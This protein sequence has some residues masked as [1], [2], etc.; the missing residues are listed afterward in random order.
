MFFFYRD[1][2]DGRW[3]PMRFSFLKAQ[4]WKSKVK[5]ARTWN[6][7]SERVLRYV[8][9]NTRA[10][11]KRNVLYARLIDAKLYKLGRRSRRDR[12]AADSILMLRSLAIS[13]RLIAPY[14]VH[15]D[16]Y[17]NANGKLHEAG[18]NGNTIRHCNR[19]RP[20]IVSRYFFFPFFLPSS[21]LVRARVA[22]RVAACIPF[23]HNCS[24]TSSTSVN[25]ETRGW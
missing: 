16:V 22:V 8:L 5:E 23:I 17:E 7:L 25:N 21:Q 14:L 3:N 4:K 19:T 9:R 15:G 24:A 13:R 11:L 1:N 20:I 10:R 6:N 2:R 18:G 12:V